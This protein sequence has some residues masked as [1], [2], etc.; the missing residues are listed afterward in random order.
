M[1]E[2]SLLI[3]KVKRQPGPT[4]VAIVHAY[5]DLNDLGRLYE[6]VERRGAATVLLGPEGRAAPRFPSFTLEGYLD[7]AKDCFETTSVSSG[8]NA[9]NRMVTGAKGMPKTSPVLEIDDGGPAS[10]MFIVIP[11][12]H[13]LNE[14]EQRDF[15]KLI[16]RELGRGGKSL[17]DDF[18]GQALKSILPVCPGPALRNAVVEQANDYARVSYQIADAML[19]ARRKA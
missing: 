9:I 14:A 11:P 19:K 13:N 5:G 3:L 8:W 6:M 15:V 4:I 12:S 2:S 7:L 17:R 1:N 10:P 18:A 16:Q